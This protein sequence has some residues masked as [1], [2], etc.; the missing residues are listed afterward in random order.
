[1][2]RKIY[3]ASSWRNPKQPELLTVLRAAGHDTYDFRD[4]D[5]AF[6]W[7][8]VRDDWKEQGPKMLVPMLQHPLALKGFQR[9]FSAMKWAD[10]CVMM[11]PCGVSAA[12]ELGW[13]VGAGKDGFIL[14]AEERFEP[15]LML[16]IVPLHHI[17]TR[18][19]DLLMKLTVGPMKPT[20]P[21]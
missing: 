7:S 14:L 1:M 19:E 3:L 18:Q 20:Q 10:T 9:D 17:C 2:P 12:L 4:P 6:K 13:M 8:E 21:S 11:Q 15:E 5:A 16:R